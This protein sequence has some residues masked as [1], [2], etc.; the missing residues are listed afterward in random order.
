MAVFMTRSFFACLRVLGGFACF[1]WVLPQRHQG[2]KLVFSLFE[3]GSRKDARAQSPL[4]S[5]FIGLCLL[6]KKGSKL[7]FSLFSRV[8]AKKPGRKVFFFLPENHY[9]LLETAP[10][11]PIVVEILL[12][13][14]ADKRLQRIAGNSSLLKTKF[15]IL[16]FQI[17][18]VI[19]FGFAQPLTYIP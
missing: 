9:L 10:L 16:K 14:A 18:I 13:A 3:L 19:S 15:Q 5:F 4:F 8:L 6:F 1:G 7:D 2:A 12:S 17:P 11:A